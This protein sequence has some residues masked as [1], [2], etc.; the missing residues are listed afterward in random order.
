M[1]EL[2]A[3]AYHESLSSSFKNSKKQLLFTGLTAV[4]SGSIKRFN[5]NQLLISIGPQSSKMNENA[6]VS[7][8]RKQGDN[9]KKY[10]QS[11]VQALYGFF[12]L[13]GVLSTFVTR[14][15]LGSYQSNLNL[16]TNT[17]YHSAVSVKEWNKNLEFQPQ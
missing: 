2:W 12:A 14:P 16:T 11:A 15:F 4:C 3:R 9:V 17:E 8:F 6:S 13:G 7:P 10:Q 1:F 5:L